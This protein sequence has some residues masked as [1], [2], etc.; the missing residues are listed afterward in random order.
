MAK[1]VEKTTG[2]APDIQE[3]LKAIRKQYGE[4]AAMTFTGGLDREIDRVS[5]GSLGLDLA[6]GGGV[7]LGRIVEIFGMESSGKS[8]IA[9]QI[10]AEAQRLGHRVAYLDFENALDT[11]YMK[12]LGCD[13]D[14]MIISNPNCG[15]DGF[16]IA[17]MLMENKYVNVIVFDSVAS[18]LTKAEINGEVGDS[19]IGT[20]ARMMSQGLKKIT[21]IAAK[22]NCVCIFINQIRNKI[23]V[24]FGSPE[25]TSGGLGLQF[26]SSV[27]MRVSRTTAPIKDGEEAIG[28]ETK[29]K[30]I[31]NK[32]APPFREA[33]F[34][35]IYNKGISRVGEILAFGVKYGFLERAGAYYRY[36]GVNVAQ[37]EAKAL[38][39]LEENPDLQE[40]LFLK[41]KEKALNTMSDEEVVEE[42]SDAPSEELVEKD[43]DNVTNFFPDSEE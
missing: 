2:A 35:I 31:K 12:A 17:A 16:N 29:V 11:R 7:P 24:M 39:W 30:V 41:I 14:N 8:T 6:L 9:L 1:K 23:G 22:A 18:M 26:Y 4:D 13:L 34:K 27:R 15:E 37:G 28:N 38:K 5:S 19:F 33:T 25:T 36:E 40:E 21:P 20:Q 3:A 10:C 43:F 42:D 32:V